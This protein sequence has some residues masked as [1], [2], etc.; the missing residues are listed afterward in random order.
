[1]GGFFLAKKYFCGIMGKNDN[2][3]VNFVFTKEDILKQL[4]VFK[5]AK[6]KTVILHSSFEPRGVEPHKP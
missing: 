3:V 2:K 5:A 4:E 1:M 6:G